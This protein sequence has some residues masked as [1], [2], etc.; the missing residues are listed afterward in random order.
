M[1]NLKH[2]FHLIPVIALGF[3]GVFL[4]PMWVSEGY[5]QDLYPMIGSAIAIYGGFIA[6]LVWYLKNKKYF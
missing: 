3:A 4:Y 1:N 6:S 2:I 5:L